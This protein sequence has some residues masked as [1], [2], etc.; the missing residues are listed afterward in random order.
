MKLGEPRIENTSQAYIDSITE[1]EQSMAPSFW[2][3]ERGRAKIDEYLRIDSWPYFA[4]TPEIEKALQF[5]REKDAQAIIS[6][7]PRFLGSETSAMAIVARAS[8]NRTENKTL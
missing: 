2:V 4:W 8:D 7:L 3:I 5:N 1:D 6:L